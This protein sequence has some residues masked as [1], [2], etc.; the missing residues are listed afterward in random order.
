VS[1]V[2]RASARRS[3]FRRYRYLIHGNGGP[4]PAL[5]GLNFGTPIMTNNV[6][7][8]MVPIIVGCVLGCSDLSARAPSDKQRLLNS[9]I[10]SMGGKSSSCPASDWSTEDNKVLDILRS[11]RFEIL[12]HRLSS[13][14]DGIFH[15]FFLH[16]AELKIQIHA[17]IYVVDNECSS[18]S[19]GQIV[20]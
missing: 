14:E 9:V 13:D 2:G 18:Y 6:F 1:T 8:L 7:K 16:A 17:T 12:S 4:R 3:S 5:R 15:E 20:T 19:F 10:A 11:H